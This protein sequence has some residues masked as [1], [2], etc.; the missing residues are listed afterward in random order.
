MTREMS[1]LCPERGHCQPDKYPGQKQFLAWVSSSL[2]HF[3]PVFR[4]LKW[5]Q[6]Q[7][8]LPRSCGDDLRKHSSGCRL[9]AL[10]SCSRGG[11]FKSR[12]H[13]PRMAEPSSPCWKSRHSRLPGPSPSETGKHEPVAR[14]EVGVAWEPKTLAE[15]AAR[16]ATRW[17]SSAGTRCHVRS[18]RQVAPMTVHSSHLI[19]LGPT[20][21][22]RTGKSS[23]ASRQSNIGCPTTRS[24]R[25]PARATPAFS[26]RTSC[27]S[28]GTA[29][30]STSPRYPSGSG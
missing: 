29:A 19:L 17:S 10:D 20:D 8:A 7:V 27:R 24:R 30:W 11:R 1:F 3:R 23:S 13:V 21:H 22:S 25:P 4:P 16:A 9:R 12:F 2:N 6:V 14:T 5:R 18:P 26:T 28:S 15:L